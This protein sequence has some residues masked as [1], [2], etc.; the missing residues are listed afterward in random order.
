MLCKV[1]ISNSLS[2]KNN[3]V[4]YFQGN[5]RLCNRIEFSQT[6]FHDISKQTEK[7]ARIGKTCSLALGD[8]YN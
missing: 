2:K 1:G 8:S 7:R 5:F 6:I 4:H 3:L